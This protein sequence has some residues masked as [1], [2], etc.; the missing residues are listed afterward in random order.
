MNDSLRQPSPLKQVNTIATDKT[1]ATQKELIDDNILLKPCPFC[2]FTYEEYVK[3]L[4]KCPTAG[5]Y[6]DTYAPKLMRDDIFTH[7]WIVVC[8]NCGM[9]CTGHYKS[10]HAITEAWNERP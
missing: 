5:R 3:F 8:Q 10:I 9:V 2:G 7:C 1:E 6:S 4:K